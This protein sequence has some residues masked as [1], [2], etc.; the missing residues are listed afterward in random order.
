MREINGSKL[1]REYTATTCANMLEFE[2][3]A[4]REKR[5]CEGAEA[6]DLRREDGKEDVLL[7]RL[8]KMTSA[9]VHIAFAEVVLQVLEHAVTTTTDTKG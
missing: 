5:C 1:I 2:C 3:A 7:P 4:Q 6:D 8:P 9:N